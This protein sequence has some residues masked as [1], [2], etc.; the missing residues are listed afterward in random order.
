M[1]QEI[2][3]I[4]E[5][6]KGI[7]EKVNS[8]VITN[9]DSY[10]VGASLK[11]T[12]STFR[13]K[14]N[15]FFDPMVSKAKASY[16]E[17]KATR[18][19]I[20]N[21]TK[22]LEDAVKDKLKTHERQKAAEAEEARLKAEK[23]KQQKIDEENKRRREEA[24]QK[25]KDEAEVFGVDE[26]DVE[27]EEIEE[28]TA[29]DVEVEQPLGTIDKISGL[30]I[31]KTYFAKVINIEDLPIQYHL[32]DMVALNKIARDTKATAKIKGAE[33]YEK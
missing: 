23:E 9:Q 5:E 26:K 6:Q 16:E 30:G 3:Q 11:I 17:A 27:V 8:L 22:S 10:E 28:A 4:K 12:L 20:L 1:N 19:K 31:R 13:K 32:P 14:L 2:L 29:D 15:L 7:A 25:A 18:D 24:E 21:P 33:F